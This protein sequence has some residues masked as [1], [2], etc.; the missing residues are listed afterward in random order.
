MKFSIIKVFPKIDVSLSF[1]QK[2]K[3]FVAPEPN[4]RRQESFVCTKL[5]YSSFLFKMYFI[6]IEQPAR[7][8]IDLFAGIILFC[9]W[10]YS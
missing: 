5:S 2:I 7:A 4:S 8:E 1:L 10:D 3:Q 9:G 6:K